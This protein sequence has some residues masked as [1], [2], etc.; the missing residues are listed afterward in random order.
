MS[1]NSDSRTVHFHHAGFEMNTIIWLVT[2]LVGIG[3]AIL[4]AWLMGR[5]TRRAAQIRQAE[6]DASSAST[7]AHM[8]DLMTTSDGTRLLLRAGRLVVPG[9]SEVAS[10]AA[11]PARRT[12][13]RPR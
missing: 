10:E 13:I 6:D 5:S 4:A 12:M 3:A 2:L 11:A 1:N 9:A 7:A 8:H